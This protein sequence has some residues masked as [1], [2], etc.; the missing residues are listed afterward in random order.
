M[1]STPQFS[2]RR[3]SRTYV[4]SYPAAPAA[5]FPLHGPIEEAKWAAGW[6]PQMIHCAQGSTAAGSIFITRHNGAETVW[7]NTAWDP[8]AGRVEYVHMTPNRDVTEIRIR[9]SGPQA[10]PTRVEVTY[11]WTGL[12][13]AGNNFVET[14]TEDRFRQWMGDWEEEL[15]YYLRTGE[16]LVR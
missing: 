9:V 14:H 16:K 7:V 6:D 2:A 5:V 4:Q 8:G 13:E 1:N 15:A 12:S 11:T 3:V 10:G